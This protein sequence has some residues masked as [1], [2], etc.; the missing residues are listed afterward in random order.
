MY[1]FSEDTIKAAFNLLKG[2]INN[3]FLGILGILNSIKDKPIHPNKTYCIKDGAL[4]KWLDNI[5]FLDPFN[6]SYG[7]S[8]IFIKFSMLWVDVVSE[9]FIKKN[10]SIYALIVFLYKFE[11]FKEQPSLEILFNRFCKDFCLTKDII[12]K[13]FNQEVIKFNFSEQE[14]S[15]IAYKD[16]L[17]ITN[18]TISFDAPYSL[19]ARAGELSRAPFFQTLYAGMDCVKCLL[20]LKENID[21]YYSDKNTFNISPTISPQQFKEQLSPCI[22]T[23]YYGVPGCGKSN[24]INELLKD[25]PDTNKIRIVFHPEYTN[26]EFVG[27]IMPVVSNGVHYEFVPGAFTKII[28]KAYKKIDEPFYLIIEEINRGNAAAI[29]GEMFQLTDRLDDNETDNIGNGVTYTKGWSK[30]FVYNADIINY[31]LENK[32]ELKIGDITITKDSG[33]RLPPNMSILATM[34]TSD[35]NVFSLDNAFQ[36]RFELKL[37]KNEFARDKNGNFKTEQIQAQHD[38]KIANTNVMWS[39]FLEYINKKIIKTLKNF[40]ST[41][42]KRLGVWFIKN[43]NGK[44]SKELFAEKVLKYLWDDVFK[45][46]RAE[47]FLS[48][49]NS[50]EDLIESFENATD[51]ARFNVFKDPIQTDLQQNLNNENGENA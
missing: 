2:S 20:I 32:N 42:D 39:S 8:N 12:F 46:K 36:R 7:N 10:T 26:A 35:Q 31:I 43:E 1:Y 47:I 30:Y 37:I 50:L 22:Q 44:I 5:C 21:D 4:S 24:T 14:Q 41:E 51:N 25:V 38:A 34:N 19:T 27:Q 3:K 45:F 48:E 23:I 40:S 11:A 49:I 15:R 28:A 17:E 13:W 9:Q 29:F 6:G 18:S 16:I 33:V